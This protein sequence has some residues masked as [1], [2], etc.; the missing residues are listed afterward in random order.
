MRSTRKRRHAPQMLDSTTP[1]LRRLA[2]S[3]YRS[4]YLQLMILPGLAYLGIGQ[5]SQAIGQL[6]L[7]RRLDPARARLLEENLA[8]R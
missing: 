2:M 8:I 7:L 5:R 3:L 4:R 6:K 1:P